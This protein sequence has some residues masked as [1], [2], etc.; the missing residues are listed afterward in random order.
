MN[1]KF[2]CLKAYSLYSVLYFWLKSVKYNQII[3]TF[4]FKIFRISAIFI[5][6]TTNGCRH[7]MKSGRAACRPIE[8]EEIPTYRDFSV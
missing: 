3:E 4:R 6:S 8:E 5:H 2:A 1:T 7:L